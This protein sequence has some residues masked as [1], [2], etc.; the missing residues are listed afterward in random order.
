[1]VGVIKKIIQKCSGN[2]W[3]AALD[4][5]TTKVTESLRCHLHKPQSRART[6]AT[7]ENGQ[8]IGGFQSLVFK[9]P[10]LML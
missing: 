4:S 10:Q 3:Q 6:P 5:V 1:M 8:A 7:H 2:K 9:L